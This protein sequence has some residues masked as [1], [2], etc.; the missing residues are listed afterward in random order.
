Q[1][2]RLDKWLKIARVFKTRSQA[3]NA[4]DKGEVKVNGEKVKAAKLIRP[5]D[6]LTV[7]V[8]SH[9]R[10][11]EVLDISF[12]S[13][14]AKEARELY[15]EEQEHKL[16]EEDLALIRLMKKSVIKLPGRPTKKERRNLMKLRGY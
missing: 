16:P 15:R 2:M 5:G 4:C 6:K 10:E 13:V 14:S 3:T 11:L 9:Y 7:K 12:K 1:S 8:H